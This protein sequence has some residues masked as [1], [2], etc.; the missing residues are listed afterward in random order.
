MGR[1]IFRPMLKVNAERSIHRHARDGESKGPDTRRES[2]MAAIGERMAATRAEMKRTGFR[3]LLGQSISLTHLHILA[4]LR[5]EGPLPVSEL[6][7]T[8][9]VS[10]ASATGIVS[11]MEER[12]LVARA[13][14]AADR[15][16][17]IVR[18]A[19]EGHTALDQIEGRGR[20]H[21]ERLLRRLTVQELERLHDGLGALDRARGEVLA[22]EGADSASG[23]GEG[24]VD[25]TSLRE[26]RP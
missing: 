4:V 18:L 1:L 6:A 13:R 11:R 17:V 19:T 12:G 24:T 26:V 14:G 2:L 7:R 15:R 8:L 3:R 22:E 23:G 16:V 25:S 20:E 21:F 10:V 9:D 5:A